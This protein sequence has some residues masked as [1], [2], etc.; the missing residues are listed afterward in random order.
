MKKLFKILVPC[1]AIV[2]GLTSCDD[3]MGSKASIDAKFEKPSNVT[4]TVTKA[5]AL[6]FSSFAAEGSV[7]ATEGVIEVGFLYADNAE[8]NNA[9]T[10]AADEVATSFAIEVDGLKDDMTYYVCAYA[11]TKTEGMVKSEVKSFALPKA[12]EFA[13][14]YLFGTYACVDIDITTGEPDGDTY[15]VKIEQY[16]GLW[17][18]VA[19]TN[20]WGGGKTI[21]GTVDFENKTITTDP[22][23]VIYV[24]PDYGNIYIYGLVFD[25]TGSLAGYKKSAVLN[26]DEEGNIEIDYWT[27]IDAESAWGYYVSKMKKMN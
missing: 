22:S 16:N 19:I 25:E 6:T 7:N 27:A 9:T 21:I 2:A 14:T 17:N 11:F 23:S 5:E 12:P 3:E 26:Y 15:G 8:M 18:K 20:I 13:D 10:V 4:A 1:L 24:H